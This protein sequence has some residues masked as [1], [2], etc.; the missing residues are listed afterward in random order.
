MNSS[1]N[2]KKAFT[3]SIRAGLIAV[4]LSS[5]LAAQPAAAID[6]NPKID[7]SGET[8]ST[9]ENENNIPVFENDLELTQWHIEAIN[10]RNNDP[11][12]GSGVV[13]ALLSDG[14]WAGHPDLTNKVLPGYNA[15][16][17]K[18]IPVTSE[19]NYSSEDSYSGTFAA[20]L[21]AGSADKKG[22][23]GVAPGTKILPIIVDG[24][25]SGSDQII[26]EAIE[27][28]VN[29]GADII[30]YA[31]TVS[32]AF[33]N[34]KEEKSCA[35][36]TNA[37]SKGIITIAPA[38][39]E[40]SSLSPTFVMARCAD[41]ISIAPLSTTLSEANG[42]S[43]IVTPTLSAPGVQIVSAYAT[44][45]WLKY[46][47]NDLSDWAAAIAAGAFASALGEKSNK[48]SEEILAAFIQSAV[49]L[50]GPGRDARTGAGLI[51]LETAVKIIKDLPT[52]AKTA[53]ELRTK[54]AGKIP[55]AIL[56]VAVDPVGKTGLTW[57]PATD[58]SNSGYKVNTYK[59][60]KNQWVVKS[61]ELPASAVRA[62]VE[63][64][65]DEYTYF[66]VTAL[67]TNGDITSAPTNMYT[68]EVFEAPAPESA[69]IT[70]I[71]AKWNERGII[72]EVTTSE[73]GVGV[74]WY[75][76]V[77]DGWTT[78][79][80]YQRK[81]TN[82]SVA[83]VRLDNDGEARKGPLFVLATI[84]GEKVYTPLLPE[85]LIE[86][87]GLSAGTKHAGV[88]G[89]TYYACTPDLDI[90]DGCE[91]ATVRIVNA[92][93]GKTIAKAIVLSDM[94]FAVVFPWKSKNLNFYAEI[95]SAPAI[96]SMI[97]K[98]LLLYR[99]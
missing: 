82:G 50:D 53:T 68:L 64:E 23:R 96:K 95:E 46:T 85:Y 48:N 52:E 54:L 77:I 33:V 75:L 18:N 86:A 70:S 62:V 32:S 22:V 19:R 63:G 47:S 17:K 88:S 59:L 15:L 98:Q 30:L 94:S 27:W 92:V 1:L 29:N 8:T 41:V 51:D 25:I 80:L 65:V 39:S 36:V 40:Y 78:Q 87:K 11:L 56:S 49:D 5:L 10:A 2:N 71:T 97:Q 20:A 89:S 61:V 76:T 16:T 73:S 26:S 24:N 21:I 91:G 66:T 67:S 3:R 72:V 79:P 90:R 4:I 34:G 31:G 35:A 60:V 38:G 93:T 28:A 57:S 13:V 6:T 58:Y 14:V 74:N 42:F 81:I 99:K 12:S 84:N 7:G 55:P 37:R 45:D 43:P 9:T 83:L 69:I 44:M